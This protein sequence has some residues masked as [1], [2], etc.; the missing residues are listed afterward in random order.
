MPAHIAIEP[1]DDAGDIVVSLRDYNPN[2]HIAADGKT[3]GA[4]LTTLA[5]AVCLAEETT[6][7]APTIGF[8]ACW[9]ADGSKHCRKREGHKDDCAFF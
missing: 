3:L 2:W 8:V 5:E 4:A 6:E 7:G 9:K 1:P